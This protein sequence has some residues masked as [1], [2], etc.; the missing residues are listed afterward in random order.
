MNHSISG[1]QTGSHCPNHVPPSW[2]VFFLPWSPLTF[3]RHFSR[4]SKLHID[5]CLSASANYS[6]LGIKTWN[7]AK[8][9]SYNHI[10]CCTIKYFRVEED[11]LVHAMCLNAL[12]CCPILV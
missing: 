5:K 4:Q 1:Y 8:L 12:L 7:A 10:K 6:A 2:L 3:A 11:I 9:K